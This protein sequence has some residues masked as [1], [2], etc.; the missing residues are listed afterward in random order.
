MNLCDFQ[1]FL[2]CAR[3]GEI[4]DLK[5]FER[6]KEMSEM[7]D[8]ETGNSALMLASANGHL[9][10]VTFLLSLSKLSL[11]FQ[12]KSGN[13]ALHW[14]CLN[15]KVEIVS[16]LL[17]TAGADANLVNCN[18][19]RPFEESV[20]NNS[21]PEICEMLARATNFDDEEMEEEMNK[22]GSPSVRIV[23]DEIDSCD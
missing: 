1:E 2:L 13:T 12:N 3:F 23:N 7:Q 14:A 19:E 4:E 18:G 15:G 16:F 5:S 10:I 6:N 17:E 8:I 22:P 9:E 20:R 11:N 21:F